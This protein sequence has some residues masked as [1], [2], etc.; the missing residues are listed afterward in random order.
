MFVSFHNVYEMKEKMNEIII[1]LNIF[2]VKEKERETA[3]L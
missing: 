3:V 2:K 1:T